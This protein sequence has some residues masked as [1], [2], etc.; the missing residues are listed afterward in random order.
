MNPGDREGK[1]V[2]SLKTAQKDTFVANNASLTYFLNW[3]LVT[4][5]TAETHGAVLCDPSWQVDITSRRRLSGYNTESMTVDHS[6][7]CLRSHVKAD[8]FFCNIN[9]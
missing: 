1:T 8:L 5:S 7:T 4:V 2:F 6:E 3:I 9:L